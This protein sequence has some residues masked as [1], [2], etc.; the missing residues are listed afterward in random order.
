MLRIKLRIISSIVFIIFVLCGVSGCQKN[1]ASIELS[2]SEIIELSSI[3]DSFPAEGFTCTGLG[4]NKNDN[5]Y[6]IGNIG[7]L[8][9]EDTIKSS[10][11]IVS[12][13][14]K[15]HIGSIDVSNISEN[16]RD[17]Q[18]IAY[19]DCES[20]IWF[21]SFS[22][23]KIYNIDLNGNY[24]KDFQ[25]EK[26]TGIAYDS[27]DNTLW[28]L[29]Y[30]HLLKTSKT[31]EIEEKYRV[32]VN[33]QDQMYLDNDGK[34]YFTAGVNYEG[35]NFVYMFDLRTHSLNKLYTLTDSYAVEGITIE[36]GCIIVLNDGF[37]HSAKDSRNIICIYDLQD[38]D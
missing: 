13:D 12:A 37:Y 25:I 1:D 7:A 4:A 33:G 10:I 31:G 32:K 27:S 14:F 8:T 26:P 35:Y 15:S 6:Y 36:N 9:P 38:M 28:I 11:E 29:T 34:I 24:I 16:M 30:T 18:G 21:C 22:E 2:A 17:I 3:S 20:T 19:D 23:N 5:V